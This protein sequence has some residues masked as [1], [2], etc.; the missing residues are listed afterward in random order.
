MTTK[1]YRRTVIEIELLHKDGLSLISLAGIASAID[2]GL[3]SAMW[4]LKSADTLPPK[5]MAALLKSHGVDPEILGL[6]AVAAEIEN[7]KNTLTEYL[8][9]GTLELSDLI[10]VREVVLAGDE[11][12]AIANAICEA[13]GV[14]LEAEYRELN[15]QGD[16]PTVTVI[17]PMGASNEDGA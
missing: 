13:T 4:E 7:E 10:S 8:V 1:K 17:K 11:S 16:S 12:E 3:C 5:V 2:Q 6:G 9:E 14:P 15:W